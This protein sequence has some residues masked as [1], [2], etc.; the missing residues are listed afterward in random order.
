MSKGERHVTETVN[1]DAQ[2][3]G[4]T[5]KDPGASQRARELVRQPRAILVAAATIWVVRDSSS[6][7]TSM[8]VEPVGPVALSA[9]G[10][11]TLATTV[12]QP[13]Y[14]AGPRRHFLYELTRTGSGNV[15]IRYLPPGA[16]AGTRRPELTIATYPYKHALQAL[17]NIVGSR[18]HNLPGGGLALVDT[19]SPSSVHIAYANVDYQVEVYD[20]SPARA[21]SVAFSG[22][23][24]PVS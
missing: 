15:L 5:S 23:V 20:P 17:R 11:R 3:K 13:I 7:P 16:G 22:R 6:S 2:P 18:G 1:D 19:R 9:N 8:A 4:P 10:L 24:R 21:Q 14:W 12:G